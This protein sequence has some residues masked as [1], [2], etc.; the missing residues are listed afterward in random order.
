MELGNDPSELLNA[1]DDAR[2][3]EATVPD[4]RVGVEMTRSRTPAKPAPSNRNIEIC[5][6]VTP[7]NDVLIWSVESGL[8]EASRPR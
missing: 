8:A 2:C 5:Q 1:L 3:L 7:G 6:R 4:R